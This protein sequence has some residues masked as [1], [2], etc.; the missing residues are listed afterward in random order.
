MNGD[1]FREWM[2]VISDQSST[3]LDATLWVQNESADK[4]ILNSLS[5]LKI[6]YPKRLFQR[7]GINLNELLRFPHH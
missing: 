2:H 6:K 1:F 4:K 7:Q 5:T 3:Y